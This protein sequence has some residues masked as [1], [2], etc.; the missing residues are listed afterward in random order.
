MKRI[1]SILLICFS[2]VA[3]AQERPFWKEIQSFKSADSIEAP[4]RKAVVFVGS[5][6]F[7]MWKDIE[8]AFPDH[9]VI[10]RG[11]GGSSLPHVIEYADEIIIPYKPAQVVVYC[12]END[13]MAK[14]VTSQ[15][16]TDRFKQLFNLL[17]KEIPRAHIVFVSIKPSPS[18]QHLMNE[19][20]A[21]NAAIKEFLKNK[22]RASFVSIWEPMLD[23]KGEPRKE[24]FLNDMLHMNAQGY[25]IWQKAIEPHLKNSK[26]KAVS[27]KL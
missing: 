6:S 26:Q 19:M 24:L 25:A 9:E 10:N 16:V 5:S 8:K 23:E 18:R 14:N 20:A 3:C 12:G 1:L 7:R 27:R 15:T 4:Q 11:F 21:A 13:F 17:R 2:V 22:P